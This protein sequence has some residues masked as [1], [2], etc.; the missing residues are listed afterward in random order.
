LAL[1]GIGLIVDPIEVSLLWLWFTFLTGALYWLV[2]LLIR[3]RF[4]GWRLRHQWN[5]FAVF[6]LFGV[7]PWVV[8][9][10]VY[11]PLMG[12]IY[13]A[14]TAAYWVL[15]ASAESEHDRKREHIARV[16]LASEYGGTIASQA[17]EKVG[18]AEE[19]CRL[20]TV[21]AE[22]PGVRG[23]DRLKEEARRECG[24]PKA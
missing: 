5:V 23:V 20:R 3:I 8:Y 9:R 2:W 10:E 12:G 24:A 14:K 6:S 1:G 22:L 16:A 15:R 21:L 11:D 13:S 4:K 17:I 18:A 19:R 7:L